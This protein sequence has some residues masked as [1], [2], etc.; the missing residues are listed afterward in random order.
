MKST[1]DFFTVESV[2]NGWGSRASN[3]EHY[4]YV[5]KL[6]VEA[7]CFSTYIFEGVEYGWGKHHYNS[8]NNMKVERPCIITISN[9]HLGTTSMTLS[10]STSGSGTS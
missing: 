3:H 4:S 1:D 2:V 7:H 5:V 6:L 8:T 10:W 9:L